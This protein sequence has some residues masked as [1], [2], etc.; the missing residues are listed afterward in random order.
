MMRA[1]DRAHAGGQQD[2]RRLPV[3]QVPVVDDEGQHVADQEVVEEVQH[4][5]E[6]RGD[7]DLPL[8]DG[9]LG[10]PLQALQHAA[11][12]CASWY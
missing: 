5:A 7:H 8:V 1:G 10:L 11:A 4:V 6:D 12:P 3:G 9:Q 2:H